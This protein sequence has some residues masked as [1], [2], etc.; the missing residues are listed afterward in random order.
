VIVRPLGIIF[1]LSLW[2]FERK[3]SKND[4]DCNFGP[5]NVICTSSSD[6]VSGKKSNVLTVVKVKST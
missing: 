6:V 5:I 2:N 4:E 1:T 3:K